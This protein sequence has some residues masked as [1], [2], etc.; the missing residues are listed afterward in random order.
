MKTTALAILSC[1]AMSS[2][3]M[4]INPDGSSDTS[5]DAA[6]FLRA[7]EVISEK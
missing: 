1:L 6:S 2:C 3:T 5:V 7:L 4:K